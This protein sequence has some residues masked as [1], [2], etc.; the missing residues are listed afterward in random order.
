MKVATKMALGCC[1]AVGLTGCASVEWEIAASSQERGAGEDCKIE[2]QVN[3]KTQKSGSLLETAFSGALVPDAAQFAIDVGDTAARIPTTGLVTL[4]RTDSET[5][6]IRASQVTAWV[7]TGTEIK[8]ASPDDVNAWAMNTGVSVDTL[9]YSVP[10]FAATSS[11][12]ANSLT[13]YAGTKACHAQAQARPGSR[14]AAGIGASC[15]EE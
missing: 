4:R 8:L 5:G 7:R 15:S 1:L 13:L 10:P 6:A 14:E 2:G 3:G 9:T 12:G 11:P